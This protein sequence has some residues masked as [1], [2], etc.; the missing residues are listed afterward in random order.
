METKIKN[1]ASRTY[2]FPPVAVGL[3][4]TVIE[5]LSAV[6]VEQVFCLEGGHYHRVIDDAGIIHTVA[7]GWVHLAVVP[8]NDSE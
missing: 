5:I 7:P 4:T 3:N 8:R 1:E 6:S 2:E